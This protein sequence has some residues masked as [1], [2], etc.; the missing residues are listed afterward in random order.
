MSKKLILGLLMVMAF[1]LVQIAPAM[2]AE[3]AA[4]TA[5]KAEKK[6]AAAKAKH[7]GSPMAANTVAVCACGKVFVPNAETKYITVEGKKYACCSDPCHEM[8]VKDPAKAAKMAD[9]NMAKLM[10]GSAAAPAQK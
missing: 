8:G 1:C 2:A 6:E 4:Q 10:A 5:P 9:D 7:M 3:Q